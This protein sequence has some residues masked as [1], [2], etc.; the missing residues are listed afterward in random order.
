MSGSTG[1]L[2]LSSIPLPVLVLITVAVGCG[3][4]RVA[5]APLSG[6]VMVDGKPAAGA[7]VVF[8]P[9][10]G[11]VAAGAEKLR[12]MGRTDDAGDFV[13]GTWESSDGAPAGTWKA[14]IEWYLAEGAAADADPESSETEVDRLGGA[15]ADPDTSPLRVEIPPGG[16]ALPPFELQS[17]R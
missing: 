13:V 14:T 15:Y 2:P 17:K 11:T 12:P 6:R 9:D 7:V 16:A 3:D 5:T 10:L 4:G 8:H 1:M